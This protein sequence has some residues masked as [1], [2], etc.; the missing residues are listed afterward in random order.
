MDEIRTVSSLDEMSSDGESLQPI[1]DE[2][3]L[4]EL[5]KRATGGQ[6]IPTDLE[7]LY[8]ERTGEHAIFEEMLTDPPSESSPCVLFIEGKGGIGK[9]WLLSRF[10]HMCNERSIKHNNQL[11][12]LYDTEHHS[13]RGIIDSIVKALGLH[14]FPQV[15]ELQNQIDR[16]E[17]RGQRGTSR[18]LR[19]KLKDLFL[20]EVKLYVEQLVSDVQDRSRA[21]VLLFDTFEY[22]QSGQVGRWMAR[23]LLPRLCNLPVLVILAGREPSGYGRE[24][25]QQSFV[26]HHRLSN[27]S[28]EQIESY[29]KNYI[30]ESDLLDLHWIAERIHELT[31]GGEPLWV[32]A[33]DGSN[34]LWLSGIDPTLDI[35]KDLQ[36]DK[37]AVAR[38]KD[39]LQST[40]EQ[41]REQLLKSL[42]ERLHASPKWLILYAARLH[43]RFN[44]NIANCLTESEIERA[45][46]AEL[47]DLSFVKYRTLAEGESCLLHD[48]ICEEVNRIFWRGRI[49]I[50]YLREGLESGMFAPTLSPLVKEALNSTQGGNVARGDLSET[51][52]E[53]DRLAISEY[54]EP[55][56]A[57]SEAK[58]SHIKALMAE[59]FCYELRLDLETT[60]SR[61]RRVH[62]EAFEASDDGF[63]GQL[64]TAVLNTWDPDELE[65]SE[66]ES[67]SRKQILEAVKIRQ[68][69]SLIAYGGDELLKAIE[70]LDTQLSRRPSGKEVVA[71]PLA[72]DI[73][74]TLG[75]AYGQM[76]EVAKALMHR[77]QAISMY[78]LLA[79]H[80]EW[81]LALQLDF[82]G[83]TLAQRGD[84]LAADAAWDESLRIARNLSDLYRMSSV[85]MKWASSQS[86]RGVFSK[87]LGYA[88]IAESGFRRVNDERS[89]GLALIIQAQ[90]YQAWGKFTHSRIALDQAHD[91]SEYYDNPDDLIR[92][93]LSEG[94]FYRRKA[95][96]VEVN[97][98]DIEARKKR[99]GYLRHARERI[100]YAIEVAEKHRYGR[101]ATRA[102]AEMGSLLCDQA[103]PLANTKQIAA[104]KGYWR[105]A[106][107]IF[108]RS[109]REYQKEE[110]HF[111]TADLLDDLC[112]LYR[113]KHKAGI[114]GSEMDKFG[115]CLEKLDKIAKKH[116]FPRY[117][118]RVAEM[119]ARL[120]RE[121]DRVEDAVHHYVQACAQASLHTHGGE[122]FR[123]A[124]DRLVGELEVLLQEQSD[125]AKL[126]LV[127]QAHRLWSRIG[128]A[129][130]H[131][132]FTQMC[133]RVAYP[134][135]A[136][137]Y[138][139]E[140]DDKHEEALKEY[141]DGKRENAEELFRDAFDF[142]VKA[143]ES[144]GRLTEAS[145]DS[146]RA[147][148]E[149]V[150]KLERRLYDLPSIDLTYRFSV[151]VE[152]QWRQQNQAI[153]HPAVMEM[154]QQI[155]EM[156]E[157]IQ[158]FSDEADQ[159]IQDAS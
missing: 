10:L 67:R 84:L 60:W 109:L 43:R 70:D 5:G 53:I 114:N 95:Q 156:Y 85:T 145:Y 94:E 115:I 34:L 125:D 76:G 31:N 48:R 58:R 147:Y 3:A 20:S 51:C 149:M 107:E 71:D 117:K 78:R 93:A 46:L 113:D 111:K 133:N 66:S 110:S 33:A 54:Y 18:E 104:A 141:Q 56:I 41:Y 24:L 6:V 21:I 129:T 99:E 55:V 148:M 30:P 15:R 91:F 8:L 28:V 72:A 40:P 49:S 146:Y 57:L 134:A 44:V 29:L 12:D 87:A 153:D 120:A 106:E 97:E 100:K 136:R 126:P 17:E 98:G 139:S 47:S 130:T 88:K 83:Q 124:Y 101:L 50:D 2:Q 38:F 16:A 143:C 116:N 11:I 75:Y 63:C 74:A 36:E 151:E 13:I 92:L 45:N 138:L 62:Y 157:L 25:V 105:E 81:D 68:K 26:R 73:H 89:L 150:T 9:T 19:Q 152:D 80:W 119:R 65:S 158:K 79:P 32:V 39:R 142:Y 4:L 103:R 42:M 96:H 140:A 132:Q 128:P 144:I 90:I 82:Q 123:T 22:V 7:K 112:G 64:E 108:Q 122:T 135:Q 14:H 35:L 127:Q 27:F 69:W 37:E 61:W 154:C 52:Q 121:K 23:E 59:Q 77:G 1:S 159:D 155:Q 118:S 86:Q 137:V 102:R 131:P